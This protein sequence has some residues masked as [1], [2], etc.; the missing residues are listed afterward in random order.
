MNLRVF[1]SKHQDVFTA[2]GE[3]LEQAES[4]GSLLGIAWNWRSDELCFPTR[5]HDGS[6]QNKRQFLAYVAGFYD[7]LGLFTLATL[8]FKV[9]LRHL[10][11]K[12][13]TWD[14]PFEW[15]EQQRVDALANQFQEQSPKLK[16]LISLG[17]KWK[18]KELHI[19]ADASKEAYAAVTYIFMNMG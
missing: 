17:T 5:K 18:E 6:A 15:E 7:P 13:Y 10:W 14:E 11:S 9:F 16:R 3:D 19:F 8:P 12:Q 2:L 1:R 4:E